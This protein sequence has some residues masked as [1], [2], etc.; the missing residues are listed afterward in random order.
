MKVLLMQNRTP[1]A[2]EPLIIRL[3]YSARDFQLALSALDFFLEVGE[4]EKYSHIELRRFRCYLDMAAIAYC[5]PFSRSPGIPRFAFDQIG[6]ALTPDEQTLHHRIQIYRDKV[7]AHSDL[8]HMRVNIT[9]FSPFEDRPDIRMPHMVTD[10][11]LDFLDARRL[12][13]ALLRRIRHEIAKRIFDI[14]QENPKAIDFKLD[15]AA[16]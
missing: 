15:N 10:E 9:S 11:G 5:R 13:E 16:R 7:V 2:V 1:A 12:W 8:D 14:A 4:A 6:L 3:V